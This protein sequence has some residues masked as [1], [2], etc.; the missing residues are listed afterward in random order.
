VPAVEDHGDVDVQDVAVDQPL[1]S[2]GMAVVD[3][4]LTETQQLFV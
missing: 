1:L 3:D 2:S 4:M